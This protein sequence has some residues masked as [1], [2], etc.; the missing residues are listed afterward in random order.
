MWMVLF[1]QLERIILVLFPA[2]PSGLTV[3]RRNVVLFLTMIVSIYIKLGNHGR[4]KVAAARH[5]EL[6]M[7]G[8]GWLLMVSNTSLDFGA[9]VFLVM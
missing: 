5:G 3:K 9:F 8:G 7:R 4:N 1:C 6:F 2:T